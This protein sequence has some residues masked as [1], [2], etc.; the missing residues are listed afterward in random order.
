[1]GN[2]LEMDATHSEILLVDTPILLTQELEAIKR[3]FA[4]KV[5]EIDTL[6]DAKAEGGLRKGLAALVEKAEAAMREGKSYIVLT[7]ER[8]DEA[9][10]A[11]PMILAVAAVQ[12]HLVKHS[13]R[14]RASI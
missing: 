11:I 5:T 6:F 3:H 4:H 10:A 13:L 9:R 12:A 8:M 2:Y 7:D 1:D 14:K